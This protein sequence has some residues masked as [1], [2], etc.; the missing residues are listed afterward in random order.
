MN[1]PIFK[2]WIILLIDPLNSLLDPCDSLRRAFQKI[3]SDII[4]TIEYGAFYTRK[5]LGGG[6]G[7]PSN[8]RGKLSSSA[9]LFGGPSRSSIGRNKDLVVPNRHSVGRPSKLFSNYTMSSSSNLIR[10]KVI[11]P[12]DFKKGV[13]LLGGLK[14][15]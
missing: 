13:I 1:L 2:I 10:E 11:G 8:P 9:N 5:L 7:A 6:A 12:A 15:S 3:R 4:C 14:N